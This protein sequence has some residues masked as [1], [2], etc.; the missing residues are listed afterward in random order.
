MVYTSSEIEA[1]R[2]VGSLLR[3][4]YKESVAHMR[5]TVREFWHSDEIGAP[6]ISMGVLICGGFIVL[7]PMYLGIGIY[8]WHKAAK[9]DK[10]LKRWLKE[11]KPPRNFDPKLG[12][13]GNLE[14]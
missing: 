5:E 14:S 13:E 1:P 12:L 7:P 9:S 10:K 4:A 3:F 6:G 2:S 11:R 8:E